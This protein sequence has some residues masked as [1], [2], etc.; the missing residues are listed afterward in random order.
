MSREK[1]KTQKALTLSLAQRSLK[2]RILFIDFNEK[3]LLLVKHKLS[4]F[5][6]LQ[7]KLQD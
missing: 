4:R 2:K 1:G 6:K 7:L 3:L 5:P